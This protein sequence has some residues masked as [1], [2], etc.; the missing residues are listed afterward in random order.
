MFF[1]G[2]CFS[3]RCRDFAAGL[4][5]LDGVW[6]RT[7]HLPG[8]AARGRALPP[9]LL[10]AAGAAAPVTAG[11]PDGRRERAVRLDAHRCPIERA[12]AER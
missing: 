4:C 5:V 7:H 9:D 8:G 11:T 3:Q 12:G 6:P 2:P 1:V 10:P